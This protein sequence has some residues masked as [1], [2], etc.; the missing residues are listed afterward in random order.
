V[1]VS[2]NFYCLIFADEQRDAFGRRCAGLQ[3]EPAALLLC[4]AVGSRRDDADEHP[5]VE[6]LQRA[7]VHAYRLPVTCR[8]RRI[9]REL[10]LRESRF[11]HRRT[12]DRADALSSAR[13][14]V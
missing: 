11:L 3:V 12:C 13:E 4:L 1:C 10:R 9:H 8:T 14:S 6:L 7:R 2:E 5:R